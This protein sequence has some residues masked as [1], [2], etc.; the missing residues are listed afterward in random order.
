MSQV[1]VGQRLDR[2]LNDC[3]RGRR[4]GS[5]ASTHSVDSIL[6]KD[7]AAWRTMFKELEN[8]GITADAVKANH[9]FIVAWFIG[10]SE[11]GDSEERDPS[12]PRSHAK[13]D[14]SQFLESPAMKRSSDRSRKALAHRAAKVMQAASLPADRLVKY[15]E[16]GNYDEVLRIL[17]RP[18]VTEVV[19]RCI[20]NWILLNACRDSC[21]EST[22]TSILESGAS[23]N[24]HESRKGK[25]DGEWD[26]S[27][28]HYDI[29]CS[30]L[31][32]AAYVGN[33]EVLTLLLH[34][35]AN[36]NFCKEDQVR[37]W[38]RRDKLKCYERETSRNPTP[39]PTPLG[40][41]VA[42]NRLS[43][44]KILV[45][46]G[47][48]I[49]QGVEG[50]APLHQACSTTA[51]SQEVC[52]ELLK[53]GAAVDA[54]WFLAGTPLMMA[55]QVGNL[56]ISRLLL[57]NGADAQYSM[58]A[59]N[60]DGHSSP[61]EVALSPVIYFQG[62][63]QLAAVKLLKDYGAVLNSQQAVALTWLE[64]NIS[65]KPTDHDPLRQ[66]DSTLLPLTNPSSTTPGL[67]LRD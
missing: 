29:N 56:E 33:T 64:A 12:R 55:L 6:K 18:L 45:S 16:R 1:Y 26:K 35:R 66:T 2:Y 59:C 15:T 30:P 21:N 57:E 39:L 31:M 60:S 48:S 23:V 24:C 36:I 63:L 7:K 42:Q 34:R 19:D 22:I 9:D 32:A 61:L 3:Q 27:G 43:T 52:Q 49:N 41:A 14:T 11:N 51:I 4:E 54:S 28:W 8:V 50:F 44:V 37:Y 40:C 58:E 10:A 62:T 65:T 38:N 17:A 20:L 25:K 67:T 47:A 5:I 46:A 13:K 53:W